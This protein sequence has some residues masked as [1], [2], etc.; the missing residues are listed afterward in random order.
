MQRLFFIFWALISF[1]F[2]RF[3][4]YKDGM[5]AYEQGNIFEAL[6]LFI[7]KVSDDPDH[8]KSVD[9]IKKVL[10]EVVKTRKAKAKQYED[11]GQ[12]AQ[13][14]KEY[15]RLR[16]LDKVLQGLV[17]YDNGRKLRFPRL[18]VAEAQSQATENAAE[19]FY[20]KGVEAM[21]TT[22]N[23]E[24]AVEFFK[25]ARKFEPEY[26]DAKELSAQ[27]LYN[28]AMA[29]IAKGDYKDGVQL[30]WQTRDF[31]PDG[32]KDA[33]QRIQA[34]ID[35]AKV[36]VAVMPFEDL[37]FKTKYGDVGASLS[38]EIIASGVSR[39]PIFVDFV[40]RDYVYSLLSEQDFGASGRVDP[41]T[42]PRIGKLTGVHVFV[43]GKITAINPYYPKVKEE[44]GES[45]GNVYSGG[46]KYPVYARWTK[47]TR[48][49][50]VTVTAIYQIVDVKTGRIVDSQS[51][52]RT[53][54]STAQWVTY[55][56]NEQ[57][58]DNSVLAHNTTGDVSIQPPE[59]LTNDAIKS[60][61]IAIATSILQAYNE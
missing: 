23:A 7:A 20:R 29:L 51:I 40:T 8:Q 3:D 48:T 25:E 15:D 60:I 10:P 53:K 35:S 5:K 52:S 12:W 28:D 16:R 4:D 33:E 27:A 17:A 42:A 41:S 47:H 55:S 22:G 21:Q 1:A 58:L 46:Q 54:S 19:K 36:K 26:K 14:Q 43:F 34:A 31:Y 45:R 18:N 39:E 24:Q 13:A 9:M 30:F 56:G 6:E 50:K 59:I 49:G 61:S 32:F 11:A 2:L 44:H 57:A 37:T 38:S